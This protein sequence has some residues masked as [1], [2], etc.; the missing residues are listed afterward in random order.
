MTQERNEIRLSS[1]VIFEELMIS[2]NSLRRGNAQRVKNAC[3][4][5]EK[6]RSVISAAEVARRCGN[7]GPAYSSISNKG[8]QL[9]VYVRSRIDEQT[10]NKIDRNIPSDTIVDRIAD[11]LLQTLV[12]DRE[13]KSKWLTKENYGLRTLLKSLSPGID[14]DGL[15]R[16]PSKQPQDR[17]FNQPQ[18]LKK[19]PYFIEGSNALLKL[20]KHL[21]EERNYRQINGRLTINGKIILDASEFEQIRVATGLDIEQWRSRFLQ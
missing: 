11:P 6:E 1:A 14:I 18:N 13:S 21:I 9:G 20:V 16:S 19:I 15:L 5:I 8:S 7:L 17:D 3:D 2:R 4:E 10:L 12:R